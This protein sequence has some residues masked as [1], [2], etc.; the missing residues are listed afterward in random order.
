MGSGIARLNKPIRQP[1]GHMM[2]VRVNTRSGFNA[3]KPERLFT[4]RNYVFPSFL[5]RQYDVTRD[6]R[7]LM[8]KDMTPSGQRVIGQ[9]RIVQNWFQELKRLVPTR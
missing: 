1:D 9:I 4:L 2:A 8:L 7:F 3:S 5:T 6:R